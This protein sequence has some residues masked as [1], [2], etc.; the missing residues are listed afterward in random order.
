MADTKEKAVAQFTKGQKLA[1][2][3]IRETKDS[4]GN[5]TTLWLR[6]GRAYVNGDGSLNLSLDALPL[7]DRLHVRVEAKAEP[8]PEVAVAP[9]PVGAAA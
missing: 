8:K 6:I 2:F 1:V 4:K 3:S 9:E 5:A 7:G